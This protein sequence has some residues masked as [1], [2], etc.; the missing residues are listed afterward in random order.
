V[1][2]H[3]AVGDSSPR[4]TGGVKA[5]SLAFHDVVEEG[6]DD[7]SGFPGRAA[8]RY[9][10]TW[11]DFERHLAAIAG[12]GRPPPSRVAGDGDDSPDGTPLVLTFDDG[13]ASALAIGEALARRSWYG[14]FFVTA[15]CVGRQG[16]LRPDEIR[17]LRDLGHVIGSH[18]W[19]HP[20]RMSACTSAQLL[21]EWGR[22]GDALAEIVGRPI[23]VASVPGGYHSRRVAAAAAAAGIR[24]LFTSEPKVSSSTVDGCLVLGRF[25]I[26][27]TTTPETSAGLASGALLP[28][29][30]QFAAWNAKKALKAVP[31]DAYDRMRNYLP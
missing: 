2:L 12:T 9:K 11:P 30:R 5:I 17:A 4:G 6:R 21:E 15:E 7:A 14:H 29:T 3:S 8:A 18:S 25:R 27:R 22:S 20:Q 16:F 26:I 28:R 23:V 13:G 1:D 19:S 10:L 31:G 24:V